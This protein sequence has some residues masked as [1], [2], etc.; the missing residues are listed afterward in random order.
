MVRS[1]LDISGSY[2]CRCNKSL[3]KT[4]VKQC[5]GCSCMVYCSRACQ[6]DD[7][8]SGHNVTCSKPCTDETVG[9]FQGRTVP[10]T[11]P[12][13]VRA[14][15]K[16]KELETNMNMIQL[17][18]FLDNSDTILSQAK[19]LGIPL[20]DCIVTFDLCECPIKIMTVAYTHN[21]NVYT[22]CDCASCK[23]GYFESEEERK[24]FEASR[25]K[26]NI[27]CTFVSSTFI[28][29]NVLDQDGKLV[30]DLHT[31]KLFPHEWLTNKNVE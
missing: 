18:L 17:K 9:Q 16:L 24:G 11:I 13:C 3:S 31:Q 26:E 15:E 5:N 1:I 4:E 29:D 14:G 21:R 8:F 2:C 20:Y 12:E 6:R 10:K 23:F 27:T 30:E 22:D 25:S 28:G 19:A 7:W